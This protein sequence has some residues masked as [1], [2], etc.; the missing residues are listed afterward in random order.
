MRFSRRA[1]KQSALTSLTVEHDG[2]F[3]GY[4]GAVVFRIGYDFCEP[5]VNPQFCVLV[6]DLKGSRVFSLISAYQKNEVPHVLSGMGEVMCR[7]E[8]LPLA[9]GTYA[10][11]LRLWQPGEKLD[12]IENAAE[13]TVEW[14]DRLL[15][16][17]HTWSPHFGP[18]YVDA[19]WQRCELQ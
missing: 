9:P 3:V 18:V 2:S 4:G 5:V 14:G 19:T 17:P 13:L 10:V 1:V 16:V 7:I 6:S 11:H 15:C 8:K 12:D